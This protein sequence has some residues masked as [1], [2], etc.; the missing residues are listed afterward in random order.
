[1]SIA[2]ASYDDCLAFVLDRIAVLT[3]G[4]AVLDLSRSDLRPRAL[5][6]SELLNVL[7][8]LEISSGLVDDVASRL[9]LLAASIRPELRAAFTDVGFENAIPKAAERARSRKCGSRL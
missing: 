9:D 5:V 3:V 8:K 2:P 6:I 1:M 7:S 4:S